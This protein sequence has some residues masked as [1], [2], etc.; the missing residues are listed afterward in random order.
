MGSHTD[1]M[2]LRGMGSHREKIDPPGMGSHPEKTE[3]HGV[4][5]CLE[6]IEPCG[7]GVHPE[8]T[9]QATQV[10]TAFLSICTEPAQE[11]LTSKTT[12]N[13][14]SAII[15]HR[16]AGA[17]PDAGCSQWVKAQLLGA[18]HPEADRETKEQG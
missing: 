11:D 14:S 6:K 16:T 3:L 9:D 15:T 5:R 18:P 1:K 8:K 2:E 4:G 10:K 13:S 12:F 17:A 7:M